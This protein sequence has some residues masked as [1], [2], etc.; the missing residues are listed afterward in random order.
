MQFR[1]TLSGGMEVLEREIWT[2][3]PCAAA[4]EITKLVAALK[5]IELDAGSYAEGA[6]EPEFSQFLR[7]EAVARKALL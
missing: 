6:S 4:E 1:Q 7:L 3:V 5:V 2:T